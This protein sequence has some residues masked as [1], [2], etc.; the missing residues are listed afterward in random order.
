MSV[1]D[2][3]RNRE[4]YTN[5]GIDAIR[6]GK[7]AALLLAGGQGTRLGSDKPKGMY[8]IGITKDVYIFEMIV[9]N[10][11]DVVNQT[12]T[13]IPLYVMTS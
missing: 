2:T 4:E 12:G 5:V 13:W 3:E 8:N 6:Q 9:R 1:A 7:V 11:M 10:L